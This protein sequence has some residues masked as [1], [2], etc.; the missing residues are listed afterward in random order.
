[1]KI[2]IIYFSPTGNTA[3]IADKLEETLLDLNIS[4]SIEIKD[5]TIK[6][7]RKKINFKEYDLIFFGFPVYGWVAPELI[8]NWLKTIEGY[9]KPASIFFTYGGINSG[10]AINETIQL[11]SEKNFNVISAAEFVTSHTFNLAGWE[12]LPNRPNDQDFKVVKDYAYKT[13]L[14]SSKSPYISLKFNSRKV[15]ERVLKK[16]KGNIRGFIETPSR[17]GLDCSLCYKCEEECPTKAMDAKT[18]RA[19]PESCLRCLRCIKICPDQV[20]KISDKS[21]FQHII[22]SA[23][24]I[25]MEEIKNRKSLVFI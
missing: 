7:K 9:N 13:Y 14:K 24:K 17:N 15:P 19:D 11:L 18:G 23:E 3:L 10:V 2:S 4:I 5:I 16:I 6:E 22:L 20:L 8:K 1:M 25:T 21:K 12:I